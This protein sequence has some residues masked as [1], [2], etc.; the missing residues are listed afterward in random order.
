[1]LTFP[2]DLSK[3]PQ[4]K[5]IEGDCRLVKAVPQGHDSMLTCLQAFQH[6]Y[7]TALCL[8]MSMQYF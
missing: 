2:L 5:E 7:E 4:G 1:M 3:R 6:Q 8:P